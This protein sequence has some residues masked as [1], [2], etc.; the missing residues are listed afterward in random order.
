[1][2]DRFFNKLQIYIGNISAIFMLLMMISVFVDVFLR[3]VFH[4]GSIATQELQWHFFSIMFLIG[5]SYALSCDEHVRVDFIYDNL[6]NKKKAF[7]NILGTIFMLIP[8]AMLI[9][10]GS[11]EFVYDSYIVGEIS[12]DPGGLA[13]RWIIKAMIP[14]SFLL[15]ILSSL[16]YIRDNIK[17]L[18]QK[19]F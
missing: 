2:L 15:L 4:S 19:N 17:G 8:F 5:I 10:Y 14:L 12:Q 6:S 1:M 11:F 9:V 16:G 7:I 13:Y 18:F 3:Y